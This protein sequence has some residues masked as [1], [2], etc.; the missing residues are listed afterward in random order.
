MMAPVVPFLS[1][2]IY[3]NLTGEYS[4]HTSDFPKYDESL[5]DE[6]LEEKMDKVRDLISIGRF[7]REE[8][9]IRVRQPLAEILLD[10][11]NEQ[12]IGN[13]TDLIKEE[14][15]VKKVTFIDDTQTYMNFTVRP[16]F[17][18][19]GKTLGK[20]L[21]EFQAKLLELSIDD[22]NKLRKNEEITM[23][24]AGKTLE[25]TSTMV[26]IRIDAKTGF[27][28]GMENNEY[29]ILNTHLTDELINEGI[30]RELVSK[31]QQMRKNANLELTDRIIISYNASNKI[32]SAVA[33]FTD[34]IQKETLADAITT[35]VTDGEEFSV[36]E[37]KVLIAISK[38]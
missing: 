25:V 3:T 17:K 9:K 12:L 4:V 28:V 26:D 21:K 29:V 30:A 38:K 24:I 5:I 11:K 8:N 10:G 27:N 34:Y 13:L 36:N 33:A 20:D 37:E 6:A 1:E 32:K 14:L 15:N 31:V 22:I 18:E 7:V 19:V 16:N 2:E 35:D 23:N